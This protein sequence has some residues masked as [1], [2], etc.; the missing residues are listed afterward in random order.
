MTTMST[1]PDRSQIEQMVR[2]ALIARMGASAGASLT[3]AQPAVVPG[4]A[5]NP[6]MVNVSA[7]HVHL[8][9]QAV[10]V[11]FGPGAKLTKLKDLYQE[12]EFA[13]QQQVNIVGPRNRM[14][15]NVRILGP[16]RSYNQVEL[17]YTDGVYLGM[18]LPLKTSGDHDGTPG[19]VLVGPHGALNM[20]R[21]LIRA[22]RH[23]HMSPADAQHYGV[24]DGDMM[25]LRIDGPCGMVFEQVLVRVHPKVKLE[26]HI[27]TDEGNAC[28]L[29]T[30]TRIELI[31]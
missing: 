31:K 12:G 28:D 4:G 15:P 22:L 19:C 5:P 7:R 2:S 18:K 30:A 27:D 1:S 24:A 20:E 21:G 13:S 25:K 26:V 3:P 8:T 9:E 17:S 29:K 23:V 6:L 10:E 14:I 16:T 11:L